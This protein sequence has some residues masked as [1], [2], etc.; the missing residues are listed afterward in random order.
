MGW[1]VFLLNH[2][3]SISDDMNMLYKNQDF[4]IKL[5]ALVV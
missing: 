5:K 4:F 2:F 3:I 1:G